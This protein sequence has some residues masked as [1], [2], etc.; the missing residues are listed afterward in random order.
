MRP[1]RIWQ[2]SDSRFR[3][4]AIEVFVVGFGVGAGMV[5]DAVPM[6]RRRI[7][8]IEFQGGTAGIDDVVLRPSRDDYRKAWMDFRPS[9]I[10]DCFTVPLFDDFMRRSI[11]EFSPKGER[12]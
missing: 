1:G 6:I 4:F 2:A 5:D 12:A 9:A 10:K 8:R 11:P 7:K 3:C